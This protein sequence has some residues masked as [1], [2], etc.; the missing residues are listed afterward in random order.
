MIERCASADHRGWLALRAAL[1]PFCSADE[2]RA[3]A[4]R[5]CREPD[6]WA[7]FVFIEQDQPVGFIEAGL[8]YD[9]VNG[10]STSPVGFIEGVY[11][12][13]AARRRGV[14]RE[15]VKAAEQWARERGCTEMASDS[16]L[17]NTDSHAMH[18]ALGYE[19]SDRVVYFVK[20][21]R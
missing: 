16:L 21:L 9:Y 12:I 1:W 11:V 13:D 14:A 8:R 20:P 10:T 3:D 4:K 2:H 17:D 19:E 18:R 15:L 7:T 6:H 5:I